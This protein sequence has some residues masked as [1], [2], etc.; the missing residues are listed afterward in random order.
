MP[1]QREPLFCL[2]L[3]PFDGT[4][5]QTR[6]R[7]TKM[8]LIFFLFSACPRRPAL[9]LPY[10]VSLVQQPE[11]TEEYVES[12]FSSI[13][14]F[15]CGVQRALKVLFK[16]T[17]VLLL[18]LPAGPTSPSPTS[19]LPKFDAHAEYIYS[20]SVLEQGKSWRSSLSAIGTEASWLVTDSSISETTRQH[21]S[22]SI[23]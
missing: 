4:F 2:N 12:L 11:W 15:S 20:R 21:S 16:W 19:S 18:F 14:E 6:D 17:C 3:F 23:H 10:P 22:S 8:R 13:G 5:Q 7:H 1:V 9:L